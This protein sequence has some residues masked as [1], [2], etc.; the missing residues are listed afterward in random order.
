MGLVAMLEPYYFV[1]QNPNRIGFV[2]RFSKDSIVMYK[3]IGRIL[4]LNGHQ[5]HSIP[6]FFHNYT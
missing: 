2:I 6:G 3:L 1:S 4:E 5:K